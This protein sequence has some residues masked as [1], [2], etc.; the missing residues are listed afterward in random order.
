MDGLIVALDLLFRHT[1]KKK[2]EKKLLVITDASA[3]IQD[4][5]DVESIVTMIHQMDVKLQIVWV[6]VAMPLGDRSD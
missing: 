4:A 2:Y 5:S 6:V 3:R 1:D